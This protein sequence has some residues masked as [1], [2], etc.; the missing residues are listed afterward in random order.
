M[1]HPVALEGL[2]IAI[3]HVHW[4]SNGHRPLRV[5]KPIAI[6]FVDVEV[7]SDDLKL[8]TRH[9]KDFVVVYHRGG[10][11]ALEQAGDWCC[12]F[13]RRNLWAVKCKSRATPTPVGCPIVGFVMGLVLAIVLVPL[14]FVF[15]MM[16]TR[17]KRRTIG[18]PRALA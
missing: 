11:D 3:I 15:F 1:L 5:H 12:W 6:V 18:S 7:I 16:R 10:A 8:V 14:L 13:F 4:E 9:L 2:R 17:T